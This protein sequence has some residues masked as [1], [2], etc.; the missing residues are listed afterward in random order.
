VASQEEKHRM[1]LMPGTAEN[2]PEKELRNAP[3]AARR[4]SLGRWQLWIGIIFSLGFLILALYDVDLK[5][6]VNALLRVNVLL[7]GAA[8]A[9]YVFSVAAKVIRWQVLLAVRKTPTFAR[10]FSVLS[11]GMIVNTFLPARLGEIARAYLMG[12]AE[13]DNKFYIL[14]T[15]AVEKVA[16]L[17]FLLLILAVLLLQMALPTWLIGPAR[18]IALFLA[19]LV[20]CFVILAWQR[21][22]VLRVV[23]RASQFVPLTWRE[24]LVRQTRYGLVSLDV[25]RR[26]R[27][28]FGLLIWSLVAWILSA[29]TNA[30]VFLAMDFTMSVWASLLLLVVLQVGTA[31]PSS[32]GRIGVF[33][34][35]VI[36]TLSIFAVDKNVALGYSLILYLVIYLPTALLGVWG[37]WHEKITWGKLTEGLMRFSKDKK[38]G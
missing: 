33:Q 16:D 17:L 3:S 30:L 7:L 38:S 14:G 15:I 36:L 12:E 25:M 1:K 20:P 9:S 29:L 8:V 5:E 31:V 18:G 26:P 11:I 24:W 21:D 35:L 22:F 13:E 27:L 4:W 32:P 10:A 34:Y 23:E 2:A 6:T 28:L 19:I 37:L